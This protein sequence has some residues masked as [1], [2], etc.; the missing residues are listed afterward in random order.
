MKVMAIKA[1]NFCGARDIELSMPAPITL[2]CGKNGSGKTSLLQGI[3]M[4]MVGTGARVA[5]KGDYI[6]L[7]TEGQLKGGIKVDIFTEDPA[8]GAGV[9]YFNVP[10]GKGRNIDNAFLPYLLDSTLFCKS[11]TNTRRSM[12]FE[13]TNSKITKN[14]IESKLLQRGCD[15]AK[16]AD[17]LPAIENGMAA[18]NKHAENRATECRG[19][20]KSLTGETYGTLKGEKWQAKQ[21]AESPEHIKAMIEQQ[22]AA[23]NEATDRIA[24]SN[25]AIGAL[26]A[27][28]SGLTADKTKRI[29][30]ATKAG[31]L[32]RNEIKLAEDQKQLDQWNKKLAAALAIEKP[33]DFMT[34]PCC[35]S[36]LIIENGVLVDVNATPTEIT[37]AQRE[38][39]A[40]IPQYRKNVTLFESSIAN[41]NTAIAGCK[42]AFEELADLPEVTE[43]DKLEAQLI[44]SNDTLAAIKLRHKAASDALAAA[45]QLERDELAARNDTEKAAGHHKDI[46]QWIAIAEAL[47]PSGLPAEILSNAL[48]PFNDRLRDSAAATGWVQVTLGA[49]M[50]VS[51]DGRGYGLLCESEQWRVDAMITEAISDLSNL[52]IMVLDRMD[53]LDLPARAQFLKWVHGLATRQ[54]IETCIIGATLKEPPKTPPTFQTFW[55]ENGSVAAFKAA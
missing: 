32:S 20:W 8:D 35:D 34:C 37:P 31:L 14:A 54:E 39:I 49:D 33:V 6:Q 2:I 51:A 36:A 10:S 55:I 19:A 50:S 22:T 17:V 5:K 29:A 27:Q 15:P 4:A 23:K 53:V 16:V 45:Q 13:L 43:L 26:R 28:I 38:E 41:D 1:G 25:Q 11:D 44:E 24:A 9:F 7:V 47:S 42:A 30:L 40:M 18:G 3:Q 48:K 12:L 46:A 21:V 52:S